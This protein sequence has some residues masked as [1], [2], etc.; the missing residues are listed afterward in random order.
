MC[1]RQE[2]EG[3]CVGELRSGAGL[4]SVEPVLRQ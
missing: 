3:A 2:E 4:L 1:R